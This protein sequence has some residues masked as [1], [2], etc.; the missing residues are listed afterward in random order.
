MEA[1]QSQQPNEPI[2]LHLCN[3]PTQPMKNLGYDKHYKYNSDFKEP[4]SK[5]Y[6]PTSLIGVTFLEEEEYDL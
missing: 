3:A 6:L 2:P 5:H 4:L 1:I